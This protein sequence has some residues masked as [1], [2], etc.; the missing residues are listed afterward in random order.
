MI[1]A[2]FSQIEESLRNQYNIGF[3]P[4]RKDGHGKFHKIE[5]TVKNR[6]LVVRTRVLVPI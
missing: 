6:T 2:V 5:L 4:E 1:E 3:T